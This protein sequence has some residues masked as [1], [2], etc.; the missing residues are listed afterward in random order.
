[1]QLVV[2]NEFYPELAAFALTKFVQMEGS[3]PYGSWKDIKYFCNYMLDHGVFI[4]D[5]LMQHA[6]QLMLGQIELDYKDGAK[7]T[8]A[9]KWVPREK[10]GKFNWIFEQ[11][12]YTMF[13]RYIVTASNPA[14]IVRAQKKS[15]MEFRKICSQINKQLGTTQIY[16][17]SNQWSKIDHSRTTSIT[18]S[19]QKKAFL[20]IK[21]DGTVRTEL[22]DR[23][24]CADNFRLLIERAK[25]GDT[26]IKGKRVGLNHFTVQAFELIAQKHCSREFDHD[27]QTEIDLLNSQWRDN[28]AQTGA[29]GQMIAMCD[30]SGSMDGDPRDVCFALGIRVAEKSILGK[31]V[32]SFSENPTWHNL[33]DCDTFVEMVERLQDGEVGFTTKFYKALAVILD[34]IIEKALTPPE[35]S[36]LVL[37][38]FSDMQMDAAGG[39]HKEN[40]DTVYQNIEKMYAEAGIRVHGQPFVPPHLLFWNLRSTSGF[41]TLSSQKNVSMMSGFSPALLNLFCEKGI[42]AL[43]SCTPWSLLLESLDKPRYSC[44][45]DKIDDLFMGK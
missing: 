15:K 10:C 12:A 41:P 29:L 42:D 26:E 36:N 23:I 45:D 2:W 21:K 1:M 7:Q 34:A 40:M 11:L 31:R 20:N 13:R 25:Q 14:A 39:M 16:Q 28:A 37:A 30:F 3:H 5:P 17:C 35:V 33:D 27:L 18:I 8:L 32:L 19:K 43:N 38:V 44:L 9:G 22:P 24:Q 4:T 6:F